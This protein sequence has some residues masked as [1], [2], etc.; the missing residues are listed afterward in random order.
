VTDTRLRNSSVVVI[1][2]MAILAL[3]WLAYQPGTNSVFL[4]D[5]AANLSGLAS[6]EDAE[7]ALQ[8]VTSGVA[9][10]TG[11]PLSLA[12]FV[13]QASGWSESP[14]AFIRVNIVIHLV[15]ALLACL[16]FL[17]LAR[18]RKVDPPNDLWI[19]VAAMALWMFLPLLASSSL[20]I[21]QR[22]AT[23]AATFSLLGLNGYLYARSRLDTDANSALAGMTMAL[24][25][26]T[27]LAVLSK[28]NGALLPSLVLVLEATL[29]QSPAN[30]GART[31]RGWQFVCLGLPTL[32]I[33]LFLASKLPY[34]D[35]TVLRRG[36]TGWE[37]LIT[38]AQVLWDYVFNAFVAR[39][40]RYGPF[41]DGYPLVRSIL[42]PVAFV[43]VASWLLLVSGALAWRRK[44]PLAAFAVLWFVTGHLLESTT[45]PLELYFEHRNYI[46][47]LGPVFALSCLLLSIEGQYR[48]MAR[49]AVGAYVLLNAAILFSVTSLWGKPLE[50]AAN[51]KLHS[52][53]SVRAAAHL[54]AR[55]MTEIA[56]PVGVIT[57]QEFVAQNP[58]YA[59]LRLHELAV[60]C[61]LASDRDYTPLVEDL[62]TALPS[63]RFD[64]SV[65]KLLDGLMLA[66]SETD[67]NGIDRETGRRL[68]E[69]VA[70]NPIYASNRRFMSSYHLLL[71]G[72]AMEDGDQS[73][74]TREL[75]RARS[76][77]RNNKV[78]ALIVSRLAAQRRF[79]EARDYIEQVDAAR[80]LHPLRRLSMGIA[81]KQLRRQVDLLEMQAVNTSPK[82]DNINGS[83]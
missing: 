9:G 30:V 74:A 2:V 78:D 81:L 45:V 52:P 48:N 24:L 68:A 7:T 8:F 6:I 36:M 80:P 10:P 1:A 14:P 51:W 75:E 44:Y 11:R 18:A 34:S 25:L 63:I 71:A 49:L 21:V 76:A 55:Q 50:A 57:L 53:G 59:Y 28:E 54:A 41:H 61:R 4:L 39:P 58:E 47:L 73:A 3:G 62:E 69:A 64:N 65:A 43:A 77:W 82:A 72:I 17:Q 20:M 66:I 42:D 12:T 29:L 26:G 56:G 23:L 15:N 60:S 19:A 46:P 35:D 38:Q 40:A 31:W 32:V 83:G 37:R 27:L 33:L 79:E 16:F 70:S 67:C 22:M 13:P 5:D